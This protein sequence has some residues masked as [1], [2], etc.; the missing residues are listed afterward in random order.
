[1]S[2]QLN[3]LGDQLTGELKTLRERIASLAAAPV[4]LDF[5][6]W[7]V[8]THAVGV[9]RVYGD[10]PADHRLGSAY[11]ATHAAVIETQLAHAGARLGDVLNL[12][13]GSSAGASVPVE[14]TGAPDAG[15]QPPHP[16]RDRGRLGADSRP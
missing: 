3:S 5:A 4:R 8:A 12:V 1:M 2:G 15:P 14:P 9:A 13:L 16:S 6:G 10:L 11:V 7:A